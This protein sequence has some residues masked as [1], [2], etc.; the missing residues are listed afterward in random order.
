MEYPFCGLSYFFVEIPNFSSTV[1][2]KR[3]RRLTKKLRR[4]LSVNSL[5]HSLFFFSSHRSRNCLRVG[6]L[7]NAV[8]IPFSINPTGSCSFHTPALASHPRGAQPCPFFPPCVRGTRCER[9]NPIGAQLRSDFA[10]D[11]SPLSP[12]WKIL[13]RKERN[14]S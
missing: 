2:E 11:R 10:Q 14:N 5:F 13:I 7:S 3:S 8:S 6:C 9:S 1:V 12:F 4:F